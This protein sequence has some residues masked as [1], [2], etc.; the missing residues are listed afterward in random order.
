MAEDSYGVVRLIVT[1]EG[2]KEFRDVYVAWGREIVK[3]G[4]STKLL[5]DPSKIVKVRQL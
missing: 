4:D 1:L 5:F 3:V 2:G